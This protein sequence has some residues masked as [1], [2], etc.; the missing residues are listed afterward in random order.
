MAKGFGQWIN[1]VTIEKSN[2]TNNWL[3]MIDGFCYD[4]ALNKTDAKKVARAVEKRLK[5]FPINN[6]SKE[7]LHKWTLEHGMDLE[8]Y[9]AELIKI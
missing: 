7:R 2:L 1:K 4:S 6:P 8:T 5:E 3:I 9:N